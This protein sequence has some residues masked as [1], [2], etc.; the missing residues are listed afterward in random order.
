MQDYI[1]EF[2]KLILLYHTA[3][4]LQAIERTKDLQIISSSETV[5]PKISNQVRNDSRVYHLGV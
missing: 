5:M 3:L 4:L 2:L 1:R